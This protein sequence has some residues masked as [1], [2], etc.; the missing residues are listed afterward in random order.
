MPQNDRK[1]NGGNCFVQIRPRR[2]STVR[3]TTHHHDKSPKHITTLHRFLISWT[4][5]CTTPMKINQVPV[6]RHLISYQ[7]PAADQ[8]GCHGLWAFNMPS[9]LVGWHRFA[10]MEV[11]SSCSAS[12]AMN[13][14]CLSNP[15][16]FMSIGRGRKS[17][18][19]SIQG[20]LH[21]LR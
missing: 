4:C 1:Q 17:E 19:S 5:H 16:L 15:E 21:V 20:L 3:F 10:S 11:V 18:G 2:L 13:H 9:S 14:P 7:S 6:P 12:C 8:C